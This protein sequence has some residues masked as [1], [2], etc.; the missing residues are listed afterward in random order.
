[1]IHVL[2]VLQKAV[3][4]KS[5]KLPWIFA[6]FACFADKISHSLLFVCFYNYHFCSVIESDIT[7]L[8][9]VGHE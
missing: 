3:Q 4:I 5:P 6:K 2:Q 9:K 8:T 7:L 1:M